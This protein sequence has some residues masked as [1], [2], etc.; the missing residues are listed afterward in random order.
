[1][2]KKRDL[3]VEVVGIRGYCPVYQVGDTFTIGEGF[4]LTSGSPVC[5]HSLASLMPYY[6]ALSAGVSPAE[7][8]LAREGE[9]A[10]LQCLDPCELTKGGTVVFSVKRGHRTVS[11]VRSRQ[12]Q[13]QRAKKGTP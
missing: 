5:M 3:V 9:V 11:P 7:L 6:V 12:K 1:M 13:G 8:G 4:M 2:G 10:Y